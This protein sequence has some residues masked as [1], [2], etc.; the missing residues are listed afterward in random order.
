MWWQAQWVSHLQKRQ[1]YS[2]RFKQSE[3]AVQIPMEAHKT[4]MTPTYLTIKQQLHTLGA[5]RAWAAVST[6]NESKHISI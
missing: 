1:S 4:K 5:D 3:S 6:N 2:H